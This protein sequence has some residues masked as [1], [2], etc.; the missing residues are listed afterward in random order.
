MGAGSLKL[1]PAVSVEKKW[2]SWCI[3]PR[4]PVSSKN[5]PASTGQCFLGIAEQLTERLPTSHG[6][7]VPVFHCFL[8]VD[9][10]ISRLFQRRRVEWDGVHHVGSGPKRP[11][12]SMPDIV[13]RFYRNR[14]ITWPKK[15]KRLRTRRL[16]VQT[17][18]GRRGGLRTFG[19][20]RVMTGSPS[21][22]S[23]FSP[24]HIFVASVAGAWP[25]IF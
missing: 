15:G 10:I 9:S 2:Y 14:G 1:L 20:P 4:T 8:S 21:A 12:A 18:E 19:F 7:F 23:S 24:T 5:R 6:G 13:R 17:T 25:V 22:C 3:P 16:V 11:P